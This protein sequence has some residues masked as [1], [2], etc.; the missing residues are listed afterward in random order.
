[1]DTSR[2]LQ[3]PHFLQEDGTEAEEVHVPDFGHMLGIDDSSEDHFAIA[4][5][6]RSNWK[7]RLYL[8]MEEPNSSR[9]AF[10]IHVCVTGAIIFR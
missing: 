4:A 6:M 7:K 3:R 9:E 2:R 10:I 1:M 8:L 5:G